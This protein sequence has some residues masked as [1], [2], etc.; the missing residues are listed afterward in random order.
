MEGVSVRKVK[1]GRL[2][3]GLRCVHG[4]NFWE[5]RTPSAAVPM[6]CSCKDAGP[7]R[8]VCSLVGSGPL[9]ATVPAASTPCELSHSLKW[10]RPLSCSSS[11]CRP[12]STGVWNA[13]VEQG[14]ASQ[15][16]SHLRSPSSLDLT[17]HTTPTLPLRLVPVFRSFFC[18]H[19]LTPYPSQRP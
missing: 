13:Q 3:G 18:F 4:S 10:L 1:K 12:S 16:E 6:L 9:M 17:V 15:C 2:G 14:R 7:G 8:W 5:V 11:R 19:D